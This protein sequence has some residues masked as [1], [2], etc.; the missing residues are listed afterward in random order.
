MRHNQ[1]ILVRVDPMTGKPRGEAVRLDAIRDFIFS[2]PVG[3]ADRI[4]ITARD[5]RTVVLRRDAK[6]ETLAV[7]ELE[8]S[9]SAS[10]ALV[11]RELYLRGERFL[12]CIAEG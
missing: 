8:D 10:A 7:N 4:Y 3:T 12:Y 6:S 5:G 2:S 1:N 9:F 11:D